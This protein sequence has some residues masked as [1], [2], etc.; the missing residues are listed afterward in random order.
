M[1]STA[2]HSFSFAEGRERKAKKS[3]DLNNRDIRKEL[4]L[5][6]QPTTFDDINIKHIWDPHGKSYA[7]TT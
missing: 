6:Y 4:A 2:D 1:R 5:P 3:M 7:D